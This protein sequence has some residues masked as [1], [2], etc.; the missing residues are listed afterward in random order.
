MEKDLK[1]HNGHSS[2]HCDCGCENDVDINDCGLGCS[3]CEGKHKHSHNGG[4]GEFFKEYGLP[5]VKI[6]LS[7]IVLCIA[8]FVGFNKTV[9]F[10]LNLVAFCIIGYEIF[11]GLIS[12]IIKLKFFEEKTLMFIASVTAMILGEYF[13]GSLILILFSFG[14]LLEDIA[15]DRSREKIGGLSELKVDSV[16]LITSK[17]MVEVKPEEVEIGSLYE[18]RKGDRVVIDGVVVG[19]NAEFDMKA[20]TGE[21]KF[22]SLG[23]GETVY[24]GAINVGDAVVIRTT[25]LYKDSTVEKIISM[26][27][28]ANAK[29]AKSQKFITSFSKIYTPSIVCLALLIAVIPPFFDGMAFTKWIYKALTFLVISC[30]CALVISIPLGFFI[31]IG[32]LAKRGILVKGS[33]YIDVLSNV[34]SAVFDKTGTIT[35][36]VLEVEEVIVN[37]GYDKSNLLKYAAM[38]EN[39]SS[40]PIAS[41]IKNLYRSD[42]VSVDDYTEISG[43][44]IKG[45]IEGVNVAIGNIKL[46]ESLGIRPND[47]NYI[48]TT[49]YLAVE[50]SL[51]AQFRISDTVKKESKQALYLLKK[52][53]VKNNVIL[54]GDNKSIAEEVGK[55]VEAD[56]IYGELLPEQKTEKLTEIIES[57][58]GSVM[59]VGDGINDSPSL[60]MSNVG[61]A[62][63]AIGSEAAIENADVVILDDKLTKIPYAIKKSK[64]I[65]RKVIENI[66]VS[67]AIKLVTMVLSV[68]T[69]LPVWIAMFAD[70]GVM[71]LAVTNSLTLSI[72]RGKNI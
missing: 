44:G 13:E 66:V 32:A 33:S 17:G 21:S 63:G 72:D 50:G 12:D 57:A 3:C 45:K 28:G 62:M 8:N 10:I 23:N 42:Y 7:A 68:V 5:I 37:E 43:K 61:V 15:T 52:E 1:K 35:K 64:T 20:V 48:G 38:L 18:V 24:G 2:H 11:I 36:G 67:L 58:K 69:V 16:R 34:E 65:K 54:S 70:V 71:L 19:G 55:K 56:V 31:G 41:A 9:K 29:K 39:S 27:E 51:A 59:Y 60:A 26:I 25:K 49:V 47:R 4:K 40:H 22:Y 14:E 30:P 46:M 6:I 53:G